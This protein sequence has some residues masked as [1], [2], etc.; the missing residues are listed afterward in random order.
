MTFIVTLVALLVERFFDWSHLRRWQWYYRWQHLVMQRLPGKSALLVLVVCILPLM[1]V[2]G[3][4]DYLLHGLLFGVFEFIFQLAVLL[5]CLGPQNLWADSFA[6]INALAQ[7]DTT[8]AV[9]KFKNAFGVAESGSIQAAH[10]QLIK[11]IFVAANNRVFGV[12]FWFVVLG[13]AG[14]I[15]YRAVT[16]SALLKQEVPNTEFMQH[17]RSLQAAIDWIPVRVL[18]GIF[19]LGGHFAKVLSSWNKKQMLELKSNEI[20]LT[21]C[22]ISALGLENQATVPEDGSVEKNEISLLDR[23][24]V[25]ALVI[26]AVITLLF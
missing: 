22:G 8:L 21:E 14:A 9:E 13:P 3:L 17:T 15:M 25:I 2:A 23:S 4:I 5:F 12:V 20:L 16:M 7:G 10:W 24:F 19:A 6:S 11:N 26:I 18:T 1:I